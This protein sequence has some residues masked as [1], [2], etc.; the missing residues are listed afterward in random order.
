[1]ETQNHPLFTP[2]K[3]TNGWVFLQI[4]GPTPPKVEGMIHYGQHHAWAK[5]IGTVTAKD[6]ETALLILALLNSGLIR[7]TYKRSNKDINAERRQN[8]A[9]Q[10]ED[11]KNNI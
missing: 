7:G 4:S 2:V 5:G 6:A 10:K 3:S 11:D 1:M 9:I 8:E